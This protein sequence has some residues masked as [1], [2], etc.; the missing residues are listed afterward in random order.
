M[1]TR[2]YGIRLNFVEGVSSFRSFASSTSTTSLRV[3]PSARVPLRDEDR[4][5]T[6]VRAAFGQRRKMLANALAAG[7]GLPLDAARAATALAGIDP[8]RRAET[9]TIDEF[10]ALA[11]QLSADERR[12]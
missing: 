4:F 2:M 3:L 9:L 5:H 12:V 1:V 6:V 11:S 10:A 7:L 8:R